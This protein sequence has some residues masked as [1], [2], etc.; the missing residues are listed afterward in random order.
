MDAPC[1]LDAFE[2]LARTRRT[3]LLV[4]VARP[5]PE[6]LVER[7][8]ATATWAPNHKR[9]WPWRFAVCAGE[10]RSALGEAFADAQAAAGLADEAKLAKTRGK[11]RRAPAVILV[12]A[13]PH[14]RPE[15]DVENRD[16]VAAA[17]QNV[18]LA[19]TAAGLASFW[20]SAPVGQDHAVAALAGF[21]EATRFVAVLY[22]GWPAGTV[23]VPERPPAPVTWLG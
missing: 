9:T 16:A 12:G 8:L 17:V 5:V 11:Y 6:A 4:D 22:L 18:L 1:D 10:A 3:S 2:Q 19:A 21:P 13:D 23:E 7:L 15:L 14:E 20:S